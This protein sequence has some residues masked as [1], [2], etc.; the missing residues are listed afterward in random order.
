MH[1]AAIR[2]PRPWPWHEIKQIAGCL[3]VCLAMVGVSLIVTN[4]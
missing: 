4:F 3:A 2:F 1:S